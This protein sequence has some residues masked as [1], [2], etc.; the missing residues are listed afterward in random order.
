MARFMKSRWSH[1]FIVIETG[2]YQT[3]VCETTDFEVTISGL[4]KYFEGKDVAMEIWRPIP[5][6]PVDAVVL[7]SLS[8]VGTGYGYFQLLS[9]GLRRILMR[10]GI[11]IPNFIRHGMVC[12]HVVTYGYRC[13]GI[14]GLNGADAEAIDT[15]EL[16]ELVSRSGK[17]E[18]VA[19][20]D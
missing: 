15:E 2:R 10:F 17:F 20:K 9:L 6:I 8:K 18:L 13:S 12:C 14:D 19:S 11:R 16:Y 7:E 3:Y 4:E 5:W 1:S